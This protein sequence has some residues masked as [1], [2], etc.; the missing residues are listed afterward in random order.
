MMYVATDVCLREHYGAH[1]EGSNCVDFTQNF[2]W[3]STSSCK[4]E[5]LQ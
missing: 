1:P 2:P 3:A 4:F 5:A